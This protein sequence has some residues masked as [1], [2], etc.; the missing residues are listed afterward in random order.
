[1]IRTK[2]IKIQECRK[3]NVRFKFERLSL[4]RIWQDPFFD[5]INVASK[6]WKMFLTSIQ[7]YKRRSKKVEVST[8]GR[9]HIF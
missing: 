5:S 4:N 8:I 9:A 1:M 7:A 3:L 2:P 6:S